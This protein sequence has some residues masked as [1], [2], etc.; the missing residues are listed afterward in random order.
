M[1]KT[2]NLRVYAADRTFVEGPAELV[3]ITT[4]DGEYG[5]MADHENQVVSVEPGMMKYRMK[6]EETKFAAISSGMM[7][8]E[9]ND[10]LVLVESAEHPEEIDA[11]RATE[12]EAEARE[13]MLQKKSEHE[14]MMAETMLLRAMNRIKI[15]NKHL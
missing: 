10:V 8:V 1:S 12:E 2:F 7:R 14:Y 13:T 4:V 15:K 9:N 3:V 6:G 5:V 11:V